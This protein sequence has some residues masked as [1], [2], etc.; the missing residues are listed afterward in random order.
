MPVQPTS[1]EAYIQLQYHLGKHQQLVLETIQKYPD[2][3]DRDISCITK[4][5]KNDVNGRRK[6]LEQMGLIICNGYK[7]DRRTNC[8]VMKW[9]VAQ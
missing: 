8:R 2:V 5:E 3:S 6:E 9:K 4:L 7:K 1:L